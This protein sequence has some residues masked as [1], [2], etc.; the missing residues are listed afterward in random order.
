MISEKQIYSLSKQWNI[1]QITVIREYLQILL[2]SYLYKLKDSDKIFFKGGTAIRLLYGSFRFSEDLDFT[3]MLIPQK[4]ISLFKKAVS[5]LTQEMPQVS[6]ENFREKKNSIISRIKYVAKENAYPLGI[7]LEI[8]IRE[9]P[10]TKETSQIE[11]LF[12]IS[13]YPIINHLGAEEIL[14]E[15][16]RAILKRSK[17][18]DLFDIW[19]LMSKEVSLNWDMVEKKMKFY[20]EDVV[21]EDLLSKIDSF[22]QKRLF[23]D[24]A[25]FLPRDQRKIIP[26]LK[27]N[28]LKKLSRRQNGPNCKLHNR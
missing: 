8:S 15:K 27:T 22:G 20:R 28:V 10:L 25:K 7:H 16:I 3:S 6:I 26:D 12:P 9:K 24:L 19:F 1:D 2:L 18:R 5:N 14:S 21:F 23:Q 4:A 17:G 11:T 13:P